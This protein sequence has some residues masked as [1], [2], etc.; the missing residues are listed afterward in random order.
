M[1]VGRLAVLCRIGVDIGADSISVSGVLREGRRERGRW[2]ERAVRAKHYTADLA[3]AKI[4]WE[5]PLK[6]HWTTLV[7]IHR[8]SD[9]P[10]FRW[11]MPLNSIATENPYATEIGI[12]FIH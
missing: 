8:T 7:N 12:S 6:I 10:Y 2:G 3:R 11:K 5:M 4:H 1:L 9:S